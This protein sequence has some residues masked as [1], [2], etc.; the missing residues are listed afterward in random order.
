MQHTHNTQKPRANTVKFFYMPL[1]YGIKLRGAIGSLH[2]N[3]ISNFAMFTIWNGWQA[4]ET[5][6]IVQMGGESVMKHWVK[7]NSIANWIFIECW[8][9]DKMSDWKKPKSKQKPEI[10]LKVLFG[11]LLSICLAIYSN[12]LFHSQEIPIFWIK[13]LEQNEMQLQV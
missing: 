7:T 5:A 4:S 9:F 12:L 1:L 2:S 13:D 10:K 3:I 6:R 11:G 8:W